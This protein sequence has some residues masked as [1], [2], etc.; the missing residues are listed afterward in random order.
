ML[1][2]TTTGYQAKRFAAAAERVGVDLVF[3][4]DRCHVLND[5]WRDGAL[6]LQFEHPEEA[7][8]RIIEYAKSREIHGVVA[9][10]DSTPPTAARVC[11]ALRLPFHSPDAADVCRDKSRSRERLQSAGLPVPAFIQIPI[12]GNEAPASGESPVG[13]PC[14]LKPLAFSASRGVIRANTPDEFRQA[15]QRIRAILRSPEICGANEAESEFIQI[16]S[17]VEGTEIAVEGVLERGELQIL[18]IFDKP[19][20]LEGP[21][22]E[23]T[24]YVTPSR[25][26][27]EIQGRVAET[28]V[29]ATKA[30]GLYHGPLHAEIR[31]NA[32]G[33]WPLE[34]AARPIGGLCAQALR[35][36]RHGQ[37]AKASLEELILRLALGEAVR[38]FRRE[39]LASG[40]MMIPI[41]EGGVF[42]ETEGADEARAVAGIDDIAITASPGQRFVP[43]PE[44][45]SYL[46]FIFARGDSPE[47][48]ERAL[49]TAHSK[50]RFR[51]AAALPVI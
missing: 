22:F 6:P 28:V 9:T 20:P 5:P 11:R 35:F 19:D 4:S 32:R 13:F 46:G 2:T 39:E 40:V 43:L 27:T 29:R 24:I 15:F 37:S 17:Y 14:V 51:M 10:G 49:R 50:L 31:I 18:A 36:E 1:L 12:T 21:C 3:G 42:E 48:V 47:F 38:D 30:L 16:E 41:G 33:V 34:V 7:A 23:E 8:A 44:G 26:Q 25:L 45:S